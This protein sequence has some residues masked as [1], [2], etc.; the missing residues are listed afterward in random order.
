MANQPLSNKPLFN[1][2]M[3]LQETGIKA[4]TLR[5]WERRYQLPTPARTEGGH[6]LFSA[7][8]IETVKWLMARQ[9]EG[10]RISQAVDYWRELIAAGTDPLAERKQQPAGKSGTPAVDTTRKSL[11]ELTGLF[12]DFA[13]DFDEDSAEGVLDAA[14][15]QF[16]WEAVCTKLI[17]QGLSEVGERW[18]KGDITVHQEH[19]TSEL[20]IRKLGALTDAAPDPYHPQKVLISS[21]PGEFHT[22]AP[23]MISMLLRYRGWEVAYL[24]ANVPDNQLED[25]LE[26]VNPALV[27]M[28]AARLS[29]AA[30]LLK[31]SQLL[32]DRGIPLAFGGNVFLETPGLADKIPGTHLDADLGRTVSTIEGLLSAPDTKIETAI[33]PNPYQDLRDEFDENLPYLENLAL[34]AIKERGNASFLNG[35][36]KDTND[37]LFQDILAALTLGDINYL[38]PNFAWITGLMKN[39]DYQLQ[40]FKSY[41]E[42]FIAVSEEKMTD[43]AQP[44]LK[45]LEDYLAGLEQEH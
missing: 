9:D 26:K 2:S 14:F 39:R 10:M 19:F 30:A 36:L 20:V 41:L 27:V 32:Q 28:S 40:D 43:H 31:T 4:D 5:A 22:I 12:I 37:Y 23:L 42:S 18:Y 13:L 25:A 16:P 17:F 24:G 29:T 38:H 45:W 21:P 33:A 6:R 7:Y 15:A 3:V 8:D 1:L 35:I 44:L 11:S 34:I